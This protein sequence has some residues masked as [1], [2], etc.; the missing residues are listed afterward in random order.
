MGCEMWDARCEVR[1]GGVIGDWNW[2]WWEGLL[3]FALRT[4]R[5]RGVGEGVDFFIHRSFLDSW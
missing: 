3:R 2:I 1:G 5:V 4:D